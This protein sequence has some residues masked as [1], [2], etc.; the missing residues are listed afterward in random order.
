MNLAIFHYHLNRGGVTRVIENQL[1]ALDAVPPSDERL[2]V[3]LIHGG[4]RGGFRDDLPRRLRRVGLTVHEAPLLDYDSERDHD[5]C[6]DTSSAAPSADRL[7]AQV[8]D[9]LDDLAFQPQETVIHIHNH[10]MGKNLALA[11]LVRSLAQG[12]WGLLLQIHDF[13]E[14]LRPANFRGLRQAEENDGGTFRHGWLYPQAPRVHYA[15]LNGRDRAVLRAAGVDQR[16]LHLLPNPVLP[17]DELPPRHVARR[18][19]QERFDVARDARLLLYPVRCIRRKN[20]GEALL[21]SLLAPS[22]TIVGLTLAPINPTE[23]PVYQGW[24]HLAE[25]LRLP[26]RFDL[27]GAGGLT[28]AENMA[29]ADMILTTS[30]AEGFGMV[31][32]E[33]WLAGR[34]LV[35]RDLPEITADFTARGVRLDS[36]Q[37]ALLVPSEWLDLKA[38]GRSVLAAY[39]AALAA[40]GRPMPGDVQDAW[41]AKHKNGLID[42]GDLEE[43]FQREVIEI[44]RDDEIARGRAREL[45]PRLDRAFS[46]TDKDANRRI[47]ENA[48]VID[49]HYSSRPSGARLLTTLR[50]VVESPRGE[51]VEPLKHPDRILD[52][53]LEFGRFR[54]LRG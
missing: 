26:C 37:P 51:S 50:R 45:N 4:R 7:I 48:G 3:A 38:V 41:N 24:T 16:R 1:L 47:R 32:L 43:S 34:T 36:L 33:S 15:V 21:Q 12:G 2:R 39:Q 8:G 13:A 29:G 54:A 11:G 17:I 10:A 52:R 35:G 27:G 5:Q 9:L 49:E 20:V 22:G 44:V 6:E 30:L 53:F 19:L 18:R 42:F 28:F 40:Y 25:E 46:S 14:D 23:L 31:F